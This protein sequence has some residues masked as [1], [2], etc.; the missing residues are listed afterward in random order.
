VHIPATNAIIPT[1]QM[2]LETSSFFFEQT[3]SYLLWMFLKRVK[4]SFL[5]EESLSRS[6][7]SQALNNLP[8]A[9]IADCGRIF[10]WSSFDCEFLTFST[11]FLI[12]NI[13]PM[14]ESWSVGTEE[15]HEVSYLCSV[16][17]FAVDLASEDIGVS[18]AGC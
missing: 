2:V 16:R 9:S 14:Q 10:S 15:R 4:S 8:I 17:I 18:D 11:K 12:F 7:F 13:T 6:L 1:I 5:K 3:K